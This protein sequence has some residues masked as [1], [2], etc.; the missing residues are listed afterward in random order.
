M[1]RFPYPPLEK[2]RK[3]VVIVESIERQKS[4]YATQLAEI[5]MLFT[6]IQHCAGGNCHRQS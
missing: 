3:S 2:Q 5:D 6:T 1:L 4:R